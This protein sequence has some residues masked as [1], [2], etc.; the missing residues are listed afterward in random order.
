MNNK[1]TK[2]RDA[3]Y[4]LLDNAKAFKPT[5]EPEISS[6]LRHPEINTKLYDKVASPMLLARL[7]ALFEGLQIEAMGQAGYKCT[8]TTALKHES[9]LVITFYDFKGAASIGVGGYGEGFT[10]GQIK[11]INGLLTV[12]LSARCPHPYD[13]CVVGEVA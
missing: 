3:D 4:K 12:L 8:W 6:G 5:S 11:D 1:E 10:K 13:G 9:G 7:C 2:H